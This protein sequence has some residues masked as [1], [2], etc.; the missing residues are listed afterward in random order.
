MED[1]RFCTECWTPDT[2]KPTS[3]KNRRLLL[4]HENCCRDHTDYS[5]PQFRGYATCILQPTPRASGTYK[6]A[7]SGRRFG[8]V[9]DTSLIDRWQHTWPTDSIGIRNAKNDERSKLRLFCTTH[10]LSNR[11][12]TSRVI[13]ILPVYVYVLYKSA[14]LSILLPQTQTE[15][16]RKPRLLHGLRIISFH[17][18]LPFLQP[19]TPIRRPRAVPSRFGPVGGL[20]ITPNLITIW[21][22]TFYM[23][24]IK[25][26]FV[27]DGELD[28]PSLE[29]ESAVGWGNIGCL[30]SLSWGM[31]TYIIK[32][33]YS[34][35]DAL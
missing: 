7:L 32:V 9:A 34:P 26:Q 10:V 28:V 22:L 31:H 14:A 13:K 19:A 12:H 29:I 15:D 30:M 33:S 3:R 1:N 4:H 8:T 18:D 23:Y 2:L 35:T 24:D 6:E 16:K 5:K 27:S 20:E 17:F 25:I 21:T 11:I